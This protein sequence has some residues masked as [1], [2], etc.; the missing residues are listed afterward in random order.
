[1]PRSS[2]YRARYPLDMP[3]PGATPNHVIEV[4]DFPA[5]IV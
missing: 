4:V 1:M 3:Q 2:P 5:C